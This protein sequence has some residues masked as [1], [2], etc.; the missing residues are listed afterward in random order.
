MG[1]RL[2]RQRP[3]LENTDLLKNKTVAVV[4]IG[5]V[6]GTAAIALCRA[7]I[8]RLILIDH[9]VFEESNLNRQ[10]FAFRETMGKSK[11][12]SAKNYLLNISE[13]IEIKAYNMFFS[14]ET[15]EQL[16]S[17]KPDFIIDAI[18]TIQAKK[19]LIEEAEKR[20]VPI[21]SS[22]GTGNR[23]NPSLLKIGKI[24]ETKGTSCPLARIMRKELLKSGIENTPVVYSSE[25]PIKVSAEETRGKHSPA[26][27]V[28][29][30]QAAGLLMASYVVTELNK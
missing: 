21:I 4:G 7:G 20:A 13:D 24:S 18:D 12:E 29:V 25:I 22:M 15:K 5:G 19:A 2:I 6:G 11:T 16:F 3:I 1:D 28:F 26:S 10:A 27:A 30:P 9:D 17:E 14:E 23:L 8:G